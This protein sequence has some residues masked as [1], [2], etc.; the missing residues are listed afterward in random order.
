MKIVKKHIYLVPGLAASSRI[1]EYLKLP[2]DKF[3]L[4]YLEWILPISVEESIE[5]YAK[6]MSEY[7]IEEK[8]ILVGVSFGGIIVQEISKHIS[9]EKVVIIS[10]VKCRNELPKR[11]KLIQKTKAYKLFPAKVITNI[12]TLSMFA[13]GEFAKKRVELYKEYLSVRNEKYLTWS[14]H[15]VLNW[16]QKE[17]LKNILHIHG[18]D[19]HIFPSKYLLNFISVKN[20]TH[21]MIL[22]KAKTIS[23]ILVNNL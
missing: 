4:H 21:V 13:F 22:N 9:T 18:N 23:E 7:I 2:S 20:G 15:N 12:E 5:D 6:R 1:F 19:D 8:P 3:E 17:P 10:S 16:N 14:F 11:L